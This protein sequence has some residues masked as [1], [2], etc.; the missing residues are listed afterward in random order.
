MF[1]GELEKMIH[2][3]SHKT[4]LPIVQS[5]CRYAT[6]IPNVHMMREIMKDLCSYMYVN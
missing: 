2:I 6:H 4:E 5:L 3:F 1:Q